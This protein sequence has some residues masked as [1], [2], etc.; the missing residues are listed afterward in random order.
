MSTSALWNVTRTP[1]ARFSAL[2]SYLCNGS[3]CRFWTFTLHWSPMCRN[4]KDAWVCIAG[5]ESWFTFLLR[6]KWQI[7]SILQEPRAGIFPWWAH[8]KV[9]LDWAVK[10]EV[11][12]V[13]TLSQSFLS[14]MY[15]EVSRVVLLSV[16]DWCVYVRMGAT[17]YSDPGSVANWGFY[18]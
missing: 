10:V 18:P 12:L 6:Q 16:K 11:S 13:S 4:M 5:R 2:L 17:F 14:F 15:S 7:L 9:D 8:C 3:H 1:W